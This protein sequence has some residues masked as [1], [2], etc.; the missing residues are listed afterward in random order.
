MRQRMVEQNQEVWLIRHGETSWSAAG[1]HTGRTD[2]PLTD[3]GRCQAETLAERLAGQTFDLVLTSPLSRA[4]ETCRLAGYG[5]EAR[6]SDDLREWDYGDYEGR[7]TPDIRGEIPDWTIWTSNPPDGET[8]RQVAERALKVIQQATAMNGNVVLFGHAHILRVLAACW[9][10][11][12]PTAGGS[13]AL[14][15]ASISILGYERETRVIITWNQGW[16][17]FRRANVCISL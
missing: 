2:I 15:T 11:S 17:F 1:R 4:L 14:G 16:H 6:L 8:I 9:I 3:L 7:T 5:D 12:P 10:N 13:L